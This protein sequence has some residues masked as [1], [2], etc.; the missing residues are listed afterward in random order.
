MYLFIDFRKAFDLVDPELLLFK[1]KYGYG[2]DK[3]STD[4]LSNYFQDGEQIVKIN[5]KLSDSMKVNLGVPQGS[6]MGP[7]LFLLFI[8]DMPYFYLIL[9]LFCLLTTQL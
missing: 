6:V 4:L 9:N 3:N 2:F 5:D 1:L 8:N 7:L